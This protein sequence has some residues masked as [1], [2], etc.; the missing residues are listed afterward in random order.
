[1]VR[2]EKEHVVGT[3]AKL[4]VGTLARDWYV[5]EARCTLNASTSSS[6]TT[7]ITSTDSLFYFSGY[8]ETLKY[9]YLTRK[10]YNI[11]YRKASVL[12]VCRTRISLGSSVDGINTQKPLSRWTL[13]ITTPRILHS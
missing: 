6:L 9:S 12:V 7:T 3:T 8:L 10:F 11:S 2:R 5:T 4:N 1:M 13:A